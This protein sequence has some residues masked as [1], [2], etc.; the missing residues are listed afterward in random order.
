MTKE[1]DD[2]FP[3]YRHPGWIEQ[4]YTYIFCITGTQ[5]PGFIVKDISNVPH[6]IT[7]RL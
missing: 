6:T 3:K 4:V 7:I 5:L 1:Q 2:E